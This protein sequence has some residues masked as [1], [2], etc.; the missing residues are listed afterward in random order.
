MTTPHTDPLAQTSGGTIK[1][2]HPFA[3]TILI[4][5]FGAMSGYVTVAMAFLCTRFKLS[6][7]DAAFLI[8][9]GMFPHVWKFLWAPVADTTLSRKRWYLISAVLCAIGI[10]AMSAVPLAKEN[11]YLLAG[12]IF[13]ANLGA[14]FL[15]MSVEGLM[16][17][18]TPPEKRGWTGAWFQ[19]GNLGGS[20]LGGGAGLWMAT[21][22]PSPW[23]AGAVLG[24]CFLL[25]SFALLAVPE[26][27]AESRDKPLLAAMGGAV[28]DL[29]RTVITRGGL[30]CAIL[31]LLP[32]NTG[33]ATNILSQA[34]VA[35]K[36]GVDED[37]VAL[38][39]GVLNGA[40]SAIGCMVAG[41]LC[42]RFG[43]R[44]IYAAVALLMAAVSATMS[45][46]PFTPP[47]FVIFT[48]VYAFV[49][50]L[51][52]TAFTGFVLDAIGKGAA[53]TKYNAF[54]S[55]S[56][57]PIMY[58]GL[59]LAWSQTHWKEQGMLFTDA[60][61]GVLGLIVLGL[62]A[63]LLP[64]RRSLVGCC[65]HCNYDLSRVAGPVCPECGQAKQP[66]PAPAPAAS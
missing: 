39:N 6:V 1:P 36:W 32:I 33:A 12:V 10:T 17:H 2:P 49:V 53:A 63:S 45:L 52:Y 30:L 46:S 55:L 66:R 14:T 20:G 62:V 43:S 7:E 3:F 41:P 34:E 35:A 54:A 23:M 16:A 64:K 51:S 9:A 26:V 18:T 15:G 27:P 25:G 59:V 47:M 8:A 22:L 44:K 42:T 37:T 65:I 60:A 19:A 38:V 4:I 58:M 57:L 40:V 28:V 50:G 56:N 5:P 21:H 11:L 13:T 48:L 31:C 61:A 29:W 24:V